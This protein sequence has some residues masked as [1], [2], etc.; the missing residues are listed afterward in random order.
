MRKTIVFNRILKSQILNSSIYMVVCVNI[1]NYKASYCVFFFKK[2]L[3]IYSG[4]KNNF[5]KKYW[6]VFSNFSS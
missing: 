5:I 4:Y 3:C 1:Q 6:V 2:K